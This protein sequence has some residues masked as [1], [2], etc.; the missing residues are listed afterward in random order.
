MGGG[1]VKLLGG[2]L[3]SAFLEVFCKYRCETN[4]G[5]GGDLAGSILDPLQSVFS[6]LF[7]G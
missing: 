2:L 1:G 7:S 5:G 3:Y 4:G 6:Y